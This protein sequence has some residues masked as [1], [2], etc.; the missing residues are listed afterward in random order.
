VRIEEVAP[1]SNG[2]VLVVDDEATIVEIVARYLERAGFEAHQATNGPEALRIAEVEKPDL[3]V[4]DLMLP[5]FDG[6]EV[7]RRLHERR[8]SGSR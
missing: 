6:L 8:E 3:L 4:L 1:S 2:T 7:M 5:G